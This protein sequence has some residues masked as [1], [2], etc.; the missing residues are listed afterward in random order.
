[1]NKVFA[2][3]SNM[4]SNQMATRCTSAKRI[5]N[6]ELPGYELT[7]PR[8]S[9]YQGGGVAGVVER[10]DC[11]V[12]GVVWEISDRDLTNLDRNEGYRL[13]RDRGKNSYNREPIT[14]YT[15]VDTPNPLVVWIYM[16]VYD[17]PELP[18]A[19]YMELIINGAQEAKLPERYIDKLKSIKVIA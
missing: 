17:E 12:Y 8:S 19:K 11:S 14:V 7:F 5:C 4:N 2:F 16:A 1:M 18:S 10:S 13:N 9:Y 15:E 6:A 3:G